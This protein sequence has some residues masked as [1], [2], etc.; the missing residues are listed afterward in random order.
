MGE[1]EGGLILQEKKTR[2]FDENGTKRKHE[3]KSLF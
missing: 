1:A 3:S 2:Y